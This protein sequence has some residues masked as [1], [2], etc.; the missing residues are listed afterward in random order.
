MDELVISLGSGRRSKTWKQQYLSWDELVAKLSVWE[1]KRVTVEEYKKLKASRKQKDITFVA[2][3]KDTK[4]FVGGAI[5]GDRRTKETVE[6][7]SIL[8]LDA[9]NIDNQEE[10]M[11]KVDEVLGD[12]H[13]L[14]HST[15]SHTPDNV[16]LRLLV[17]LSEEIDAEKHEAVARKIAD[18]IGLEYF[19]RTTFDVNRLVYFPSKLMDA[20]TVWHESPYGYEPLDVDSVLGEYFDWTNMGEWARHA[21]EEE[22]NALHRK[23]DNPLDKPGTIG[24]FNRTYSITEAIATFLSDKYEETDDGT[25]R[26]TY[27]GGSTAGGLVIYDNDTFC[28]SHHSTDPISGQMVNAYDLVRIHK[29][30]NLDYGM[31]EAGKM[32][33]MPSDIQMKKMMDKDINCKKQDI[34]EQRA[35]MMSDF[36]GEDFDIEDKPVI[37]EDWEAELDRENGEYTLTARNLRLVLTKGPMDGVLAY[38]EVA[39][40]P[41]MRKA[42]A[43]ADVDNIE[44]DRERFEGKTE[45]NWT[46]NDMFRMQDWLFDKYQFRNKDAITSTLMTVCLE[47]AYNPLKDY[48]RSLEWDGSPRAETLFIDWLAAEDNEYTRQVTRKSLLGAMWRVFKPGTKYDYMPVLVGPQGN[49][50]SS[51]LKKLAITDDW[52][53]DNVKELKGKEAQEQLQAGWI[54]EM[55]ELDIMG[56]SSIEELKHFITQTTD[57]FRQSYGKLV[58]PYPRKAVFFGTTN[59][60]DFL[61]DKT[62]NRRFLPITTGKMPKGQAHWNK[63][64]GDAEK[65]YFGQLWAEVYQ[66][67]K[68]GEGVFLDDD[69]TEEAMKMQKA[70]TYVDDFEELL[71]EWLDEPEEADEFEIGEPMLRTKVTSRQIYKEVLN[72]QETTVP[73]KI[74]NQIK[75]IMDGLPNWEF[76]KSIRHTDETG[77]VRVSSGYE[78]RPINILPATKS[79]VFHTEGI[80]KV[81]N[82]NFITKTDLG[83]KKL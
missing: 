76:K 55:G 19:D 5:K 44:S 9:D 18:N 62:G 31:G 66:W 48:I 81:N 70:H 43:W 40:R 42:P 27:V 38:N 1:E 6:S 37:V 53:N 73:R 14:I 57:K 7:R 25:G 15:L 39:L 64:T 22:R 3:L 45:V 23:K 54:F 4:A 59:R 13:Y 35:S 77:K 61:I 58:E 72:G 52:F 28:H 26:Y 20:T 68:Q 24:L 69:M 41:V 2:D 50:K 8:T 56:K 17:P 83:Y 80:V 36:S 21:G 46:D 12:N 75:M 74:G 16:R 49:G 10:F 79:E 82:D 51:L 33:K 71:L 63:L 78:R 67:Y 29:Y 34:L 65:H 32:G 11:A 47:R 30:G 60:T